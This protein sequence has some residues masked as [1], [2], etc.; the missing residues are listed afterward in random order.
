MV[1]ALASPWVDDEGTCPVCR[2]LLI[3]QALACPWVDDGGTCSV[4]RSLLMIQALTSPWVDDEGTCPVGGRVLKLRGAEWSLL[5]CRR[6][7]YLF[8]FWSPNI[9]DNLMNM[10]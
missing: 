7:Q 1:Q 3:T 4:C 8:Q 2:P 10:S 6:L 5:T 9:Q